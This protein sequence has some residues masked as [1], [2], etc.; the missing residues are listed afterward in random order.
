MYDLEG[1]F[2]GFETLTDQLLL[3]QTSNEDVEK[4]LRFGMTFESKC[5]F[6]LRRLVSTAKFDHHKY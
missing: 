2:Y 6:D 1:N 3:C 4:F 5:D